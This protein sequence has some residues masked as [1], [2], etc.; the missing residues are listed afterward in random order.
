MLSH[1]STNKIK[2]NDVLLWN[3]VHIWVISFIP[4][5][6]SSFDVVQSSVLFD[7]WLNRCLILNVLIHF[8]IIQ[9]SVVS[10]WLVKLLI[11]SI[12]LIL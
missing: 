2:Y 3:R 10:R 6:I 4:S 11:A 7:S 5:V 9:R 1:A 8:R 12:I